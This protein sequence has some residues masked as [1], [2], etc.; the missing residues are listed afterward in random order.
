MSGR[1]ASCQHADPL[2]RGNLEPQIGCVADWP[3]LIKPV[4][5][6]GAHFPR[7]TGSAISRRAFDP[8]LD[9]RACRWAFRRCADGAIVRSSVGHAVLAIGEKLA[10]EHPG[11]RLTS[12]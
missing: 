11:R 7:F 8:S 12:R 1:L 6:D 5:L 3:S 10:G 2:G 4:V 9:Y